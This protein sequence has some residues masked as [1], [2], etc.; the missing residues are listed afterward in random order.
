MRFQTNQGRT[1]AHADWIVNNPDPSISSMQTF[2]SN[3]PEADWEGLHAALRFDAGTL[4]VYPFNR[5]ASGTYDAAYHYN[6]LQWWSDWTKSKH[7]GMWVYTQNYAFE[8]SGRIKDS[9]L[10]CRDTLPWPMGP[11]ALLISSGITTRTT[12]GRMAVMRPMQVPL[13]LL[14]RRRSDQ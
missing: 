12:S 14:S 9:E 5:T 3:Y 2:H 8:E 4:Q 6:T 10:R 1:I 7:V 11:K 13:R